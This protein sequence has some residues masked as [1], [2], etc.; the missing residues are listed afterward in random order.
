MKIIVINNTR[1]VAGSGNKFSY[2]LPQSTNFELGSKVGVVGVS[3][4]NSTFNIG[5]SRGN[6]T[7]TLVWNAPALT[8]PTTNGS[9]ASGSTQITLN[10]TS[11]CTIGAT[12]TATNIPA[13]TTITA[14]NG[15]VI[16]ISQATTAIIATA[17]TI[18]ITNFVYNWTIPDGY[19]TI[20]DLNYW[21]QSMFITNALYATTTAGN[22]YFYDF[23]LNSIRYKVQVDSYY[24]PTSATATTLGYTIASGAL[25]TYPASAQTPQIS[26]GSSFGTLIG[27]GAQTFPSTVQSTNQSTIST[28]TPIINPVN[29]YLMTCNLINSRYSIPNDTFYTIPVSGAIGSL[30]TTS[31]NS[32]IMSDITPRQYDT[33]DITFYDQQWNALQLQDNEVV[34]TLAIE[35]VYLN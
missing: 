31:N 19:Y 32:L 2:K 24:I 29:S 22:V 10:S 33:I 12:I 35:E 23:L 8:N 1:Y 34:I 21:L 28:S 11:S 30:I 18:T 5:S 15:S 6:N 9:T 3:I 26:W 7:L 4:Y 13:N 20:S 17:S 25:W 16:T 27:L 14:I